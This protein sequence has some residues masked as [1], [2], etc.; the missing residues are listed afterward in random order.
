[1]SIRSTLS[2]CRSRHAFPERGGVGIE[3]T[4]ATAG[5]AGVAMAEVFRWMFAS[6]LVFAV[7]SVIA[8]ILLEERPL[9]GP[10]SDVAPVGPSAPPEP[11]E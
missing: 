2:C 5:A 9:T 4:V 1:M 3:L 6:A 8:V 10:V 7:L 11:A